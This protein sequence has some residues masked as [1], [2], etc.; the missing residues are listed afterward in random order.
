MAVPRTR[1][2]LCE[3]MPVHDS[4]TR[5]IPTRVVATDAGFRLQLMCDDQSLVQVEA[6]LRN[7]WSNL[8]ETGISDSSTDFF[9][10]GGDSF[11]ATLMVLEVS[12]LWQVD[13]TTEILI[14]NPTLGGFASCVVDLMESAR[15]LDER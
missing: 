1:E 8:L 15:S 7:L 12:Q 13:L 2:R 5:I 11:L 14:S 3:K 10:A 6:G 9:E 4:P